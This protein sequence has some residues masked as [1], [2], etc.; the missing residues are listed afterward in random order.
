M[1]RVFSSEKSQ[2]ITRAT[3]IYNSNRVGQYSKYLDSNPLFITYYSLNVAMST[4]DVG[5][6]NIYDELGPKSPL[7]FNKITEFPVYKVQLLQPQGTYEDGNYDVELDISDITILPNTIIPRPYDFFCIDLPNCKKLLYRVNNFRHNTIQS[8]DFYMLDADLRHSGDDCCDVIEKQVVETYHC[9]FENIGTQ[10]NC[11]IKLDDEDKANATLE[12]IETLSS[13]YHDLFYNEQVG[14]Y[15]F[16]SDYTN[17]FQHDEPRFCYYDIY[18]AKFIND[19]RLFATYDY[20]STSV[21]TYDDTEPKL[22]DFTFRHTL[23]YALLTK[24]TTLLAR[25]P[26]YF[27]RPITKAFSPLLYHIDGKCFGFDLVLDSKSKQTRSDLGEYFPHRLI[28]LL[29]DGEPADAESATSNNAYGADLNFNIVDLDQYVNSAQKST[30]KPY[31][32]TTPYVIKEKNNTDNE[33]TVK[34]TNE[35]YDGCSEVYQLICS[36]MNGENIS[37]DA[38]ALIQ[39]LYHYTLWSYHMIPVVIYALKGAYSNY[40]KKL[41]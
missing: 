7:R 38:D 28:S 24:S 10:D 16:Y 17:G 26:Y 32:D 39:T 23:W 9:V 4:A 6:N 5:L 30:F 20:T 8:N 33:D 13:M 21:V 11:F 19:S 37:Y 22:F 25:Y 34:A 40:F 31:D 2:F 27:S 14:D 12:T 36:F 15:L 35:E 29:L 18:L 41:N 3:E 1:A